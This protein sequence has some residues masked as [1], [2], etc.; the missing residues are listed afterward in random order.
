V[1]IVLLILMALAGIW[2]IVYSFSVYN[3]IIRLYNE[4]KKAWAN[5]DQLLQQRHDLIPVLVEICRAYRDFEA[6]LLERIAATRSLY[7]EARLL[8]RKVELETELEMDFA[9]IWALIERMPELKAD[10]SFKALFQKL[11]WLEDCIADRRELYNEYV[12]NYNIRVERIPECWI[13]SL[14]GYEKAAYFRIK[15]SSRLISIV[16]MPDGIATQGE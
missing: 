1:R 3:G 11:C 6:A 14:F 4:V 15:G 7:D 9:A 10:R 13:I 8:S 16:T 5:I 2:A 12:R